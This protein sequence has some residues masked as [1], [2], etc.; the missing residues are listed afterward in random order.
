MTGGRES[1]CQLQAT[2]RG[3]DFRPW[4]VIGALF[5]AALASAATAPTDPF[6]EQQWAL[7]NDGTQTIQIGVDD[8]HTIQQPGKAG[9]D[10]GWLEGQSQAASLAQAPVTVAVIDSGVDPGH[11]DLQGRISQDGWDFLAGVSTMQD[12]LGHG[13]HVS[14]IIAANVDNAVGIAGAAP[15]S[16]TIL[17]LRVLSQDFTTFAYNGK[18]IADYV[19]DAINYA[20]AHGASVIN[21]S[22]GWP[23]L[24]DTP[25][26][27]GAVADAINAGVLIVASAGNNRKTEPTFPCA[28]EGVLCVGAVSNDGT[29]S[30]YSNLGGKVDTLAPG[31]GI[32]SLFPTAMESQ[33][34]RIDGYEILSGTS[35]AAPFVAAIAA[36]LKSANPAITLPELK[37]RL[38]ASGDVAAKSLPIAAGSSLYSMVNL[39]GALSAAP[40]PVFLPDFK[41]AGTSEAAID[42]SSLAVSGAFGLTNLWTPASGVSVSV[43]VNGVPAGLAQAATLGPSDNLS[44]PWKFQFQN[45]DQSS[46]LHIVAQ[47][48]D[49]AGDH[50]SFSTDLNA[51]RP[52]ASMSARTT[53]ALPPPGG[54][55]I[56]WIGNLN[57]HLYSLFSQ[58]LTYGQASGLPKFYQ[59]LNPGPAGL[60]LLV[61][62]PAN[63]AAPIGIARVPGI[64]TIRSLIQID[65]NGDGQPDWVVTGLGNA[66]QGGQYYQFYFL[67]SALQPLYG[68][69]ASAWRVPYDPVLGP[70]IDRNY[71]VAGSWLRASATDPRLLPSFLANAVLP[72]PDNYPMLDPRAYQ[73]DT[74][75]FYLQPEP[76][77][78]TDTSVTLQ[79]RALD[80]ATFRAP[81]GSVHVRNVLIPSQAELAAG[82]VRAL[83]AMGDT[84]TAG[85][86]LWDIP[87]A[88]NAASLAPTTGWDAITVS[89]TAVP[90]PPGDSSA[91]LYF[92]D[93]T[94]GSLAWADSAGNYLG[95]SEF[96]YSQ[97]EDPLSG[98]VGAFSLPALG[99]FWFV[100][101][102]FNLVAFHQAPPAADGTPA[103]IQSQ[104]IPINRDSSFPA[105]EFN[106]LFAPALVG[107]KA[108][109]LPGVYIDT[110][111][112][113][114]TRVSVAAWDPVSSSFITPLRYSLQIPASCVQM[115]PVHLDPTD[116]GSFRLAL[117]C[118]TPDG[119]AMQLWLVSPY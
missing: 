61:V 109:P 93:E 105:Q 11:P 43:T 31:D 19:A 52:I 106:L 24:A 113:D 71:A 115:S 63:T 69:N 79:T 53:Y 82:H 64:Q 7:H 78:A 62:D 80:S 34:A 72:A 104:A 4:A 103:P 87:S 68:A 46:A 2:G 54:M 73:T 81:L 51:M 75:L 15:P 108:S 102:N 28:Y 94:R 20:V 88:D 42:E 110:T 1:G 96:T 35:M 99:N 14:G 18:L 117:F 60:A 49:S 22:L 59:A 58:A 12:D 17:P 65:A 76:Q 57:G 56:T 13:T 5:T 37:A 40:R 86:D 91:L 39:P 70:S 55:G 29:L 16:V 9:V 66:S 107:S 25:N 85:T 114:G 41:S 47:V 50:R 77:A 10:I 100:P 119:S 101:S 8:L 45:L 3:T 33:I 26:A 44:V 36:T 30:V 74:H 90:A 116:P 32:F 97:I 48:T 83:L 98:F 6:F 95:L 112:V 38:L 27:R 111:E 21:L 84:I 67:D 23:S 89:G 92:T 118:P